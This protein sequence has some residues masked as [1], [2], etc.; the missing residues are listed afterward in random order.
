MKK[1]LTNFTKCLL[2]WIIMLSPLPYT[3][4]YADD[5]PDHLNEYFDLPEDFDE[6]VPVIREMAEHI[7]KGL[8]E[9]GVKEIQHTFIQL[10]GE[11][12]TQVFFMAFID[13][14]DRCL[15]Y[16]NGSKKVEICNEGI[17]ESI[18]IALTEQEQRS[19]QKRSRFSSILQEWEDKDF[20]CNHPV[21]SYAK[22]GGVWVLLMAGGVP[23]VLIPVGIFA[24]TVAFGVGFSIALAFAILVSFFGIAGSR[25]DLCLQVRRKMYQNSRIRGVWD[26]ISPDNWDHIFNSLR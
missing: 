3:T 19:E 1:L 25:E 8:E 4:A 2:S 12:G 14:Q 10:K 21:K 11:S 5:L 6:Q 15:I 26:W 22:E 23:A 17:Q 9:H 7:Q 24:G 20:D 18:R 13:D 16:L